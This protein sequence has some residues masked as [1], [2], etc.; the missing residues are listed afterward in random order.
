MQVLVVG[1]SHVA[2]IGR[3]GSGRFMHVNHQVNIQYF[4][5]KGA[6]F[7]T[8]TPEKLSKLS[9]W[10]KPEIII[11]IIGGN[12]VSST[13]DTKEIYRVGETYYKDLKEAFPGATI[14]A[15]QI[16]AR[17]YLPNNRFGAPGYEIFQSRRVAVNNFIKALRY[18]DHVLMIGGPNRLDN[19]SLYE[20]DGVHLTPVGYAKFYSLI[21]KLVKYVIDRRE[22]N[23]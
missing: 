10:Y 23:A 2:N 1:D 13:E 8:F 9:Q 3:L 18:K 17:S 4:G 21:K 16:E 5:I 12:T 20:S 15:T 19:L 7:A 22:H 11:S 6:G 14:V